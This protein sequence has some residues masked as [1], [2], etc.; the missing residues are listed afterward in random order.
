M[1]PLLWKPSFE[2]S[3]SDLDF[4]YFQWWT[5]WGMRVGEMESAICKLIYIQWL[6]FRTRFEVW[7]MHSRTCSL[8]YKNFLRKTLVRNVERNFLS[9]VDKWIQ[10]Q[11]ILACRRVQYRLLD[12]RVTSAVNRQSKPEGLNK[13]ASLFYWEQVNWNFIH[14]L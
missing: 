11:I 5:L 14:R 8:I 10:S 6:K 1:V 7:R 2:R 4:A 9:T 13:K 3:S 12:R